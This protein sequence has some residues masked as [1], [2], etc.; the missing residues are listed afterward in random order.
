MAIYKEME[1]DNGVTVRYHRI[2]S[3]NKITNVQNTIEV[4]SYTKEQ[5]RQEEIEAIQN[6]TDMNIFIN[7]DF[8]T[9]E[10]NENLTI[11]EAYEYLKNLD[12]FKNAE[13]C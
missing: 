11:E 12:K 3:I 13:D 6:V 9:T 8:I 10:Y 7:T 5:K 4:A 2:V 1:L